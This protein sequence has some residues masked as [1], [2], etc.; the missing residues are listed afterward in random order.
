MENPKAV[1]DGGDLDCGSGLLLIIKKAMDP[2]SNG[3][4]LEVRSRERTVADDLPAWCRMVDH[5][6]LGSEPGDNTTRYF[7]RKGSQQGELA[8]DLEAA[9]GYKWNVR[10][11]AERSLTAKVHSR[12]HTF[13]VGQPA[14]F[15]S[16]VDAPSA[17]DYFLGALASDLAV[18]FKAQ[19]SRRN[20]EI[21]QLE[22]S[23]KA[24]LENVLYHL[25]LEDGGSPK[26]QEMKGTFYVSSPQP[27]EELEKLWENTLQRSP[28]YQTLKQTMNIDIQFSI[29]F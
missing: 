18:G 8:S 15:G 23:I 4:I 29:V 17:I 5:A 22:V 25:E 10:V 14:D 3:E 21:D 24:G 28:I 20:I 16:K 9:K 26:I 2:L 13:I 1:C 19:A 6:F 12:N 7:V 11:Q 27:E